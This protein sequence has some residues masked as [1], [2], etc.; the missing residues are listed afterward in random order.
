MFRD[1]ILQDGWIYRK[2]DILNIGK[3]SKKG[4][5]KEMEKLIFYRLSKNIERLLLRI[6]KKIEE[7]NRCCFIEFRGR[8][9]AGIKWK[10]RVLFKF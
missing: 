8:L 7:T 1:E 2:K 4:K 3:Y 5:K 9:D 6:T 10:C